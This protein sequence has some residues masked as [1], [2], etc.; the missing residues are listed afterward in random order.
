MKK[1]SEV[2]GHESTSRRLDAAKVK[3]MLRDNGMS[4]ESASKAIGRSH[5]CI[6]VALNQSKGFCSPGVYKPLAMLL[7]VK[8]EELFA[9]EV[10]EETRNIDEELKNVCVGSLRY[11]CIKLTGIEKNLAGIDAVLSDL[12][13]GSSKNGT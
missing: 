5:A 2:K 3:K 11:I 7:G 10:N 4:M 9:E 6:A 1:G 13:Y 12:M 8:E